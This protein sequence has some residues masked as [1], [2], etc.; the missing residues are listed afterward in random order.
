MKQTVKNQSVDICDIIGRVVAK[1]FQEKGVLEI[2]RG[3]YIVRIFI[4]PNTPI[5]VTN[6]LVDK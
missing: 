6:M 4:P 5:E 3:K 1:Y 2:K